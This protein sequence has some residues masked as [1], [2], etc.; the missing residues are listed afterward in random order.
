MLRLAPCER[1]VER[2]P[3]VSP[4]PTA[5]SGVS[6]NAGGGQHEQQRTSVEASTIHPAA[7]A[8]SSSRAQ[9]GRPTRMAEGP[10]ETPSDLH[11]AGGGGGGSGPGTP[12]YHVHT[13]VRVVEPPA[14][15]SH[16]ATDGG[17]EV[18]EA[19]L[20]P[21]D[22]LTAE[23]LFSEDDGSPSPLCP[24]R[25]PHTSADGDNVSSCSSHD[26]DGGPESRDE[27]SSGSLGDG[28]ERRDSGVG[29]SLTRTSR[30]VHLSTG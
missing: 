15:G 14:D 13:S 29:S 7:A 24:R 20:G 6:S 2:F 4:Q 16:E 28:H 18:D 27:E 3:Y 9:S 23:M 1:L 22:M 11:Q 30:Q 5:T 10:L 17:G 26:S 21:G 12:I 8:A 19:G 25:Q